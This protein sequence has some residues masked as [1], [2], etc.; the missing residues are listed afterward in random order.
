[1]SLTVNYT[2]ELCRRIDREVPNGVK[3]VEEFLHPD[4]YE[5]YSEV[6]FLISIS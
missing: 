1:M 5:G 4:D 3:W 6:C 2:V